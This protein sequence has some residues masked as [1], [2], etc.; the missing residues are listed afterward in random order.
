MTCIP[1]VGSFIDILG[2]I[3]ARFFFHY[4][5]LEYRQDTFLITASLKGDALSQ[6]L[7]RDFCQKF[8]VALKTY[9]ELSSRIMG[10]AWERK[11]F[12]SFPKHSPRP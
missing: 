3:A 6:S 11:R 8:S 10:S 9:F 1:S 5:I 7:I 12:Q 2:G 4:T